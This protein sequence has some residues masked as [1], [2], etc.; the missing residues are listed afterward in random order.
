MKALFSLLLLT[1]TFAFGQV[2]ATAS[3]KTP[4]MADTSLLWKQHNWENYQYRIDGK[5]SIVRAFDEASSTMIYYATFDRKSLDIHFL[6]EWYPRTGQIKTLTQKIDGVGDLQSHYYENGLLRLVYSCISDTCTEV[7]YYNDGSLQSRSKFV[8]NE[9]YL[10]DRLTI[11]PSQYILTEYYCRNGTVAMR[12]TSFS[13]FPHLRR[14]Y[15]CEGN[16]YEEVYLNSRNCWEG[17]YKAYYPDGTIK[18][19]G[20]YSKFRDRRKVGVWRHFDTNGQLI[21][22]I[23]YPE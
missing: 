22:E 19:T 8:R 10:E 15:D 1:S 9:E 16:L 7:H 3:A 11:E 20:Q 23:E 5:D 14:F 21:E 6:N 13:A 18:T 2:D 12:D 17:P 4:S